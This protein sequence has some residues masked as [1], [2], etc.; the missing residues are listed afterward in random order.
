MINK[1]LLDELKQLMVQRI[2]LLIPDDASDRFAD[3]L[4]ERTAYLG[5]SS[6]DDYRTFL[7][8]GDAAEEWAELARFFTTGETFFFRDQGLHALLKDKILPELFE[9][10]KAERALRIWC[11]ACSSGEEAY[12]IAILLDELVA[13]QS[14]WNISI[15]G[16]D[17]N[18][19]FIEKAR[20]GIY[21]EWSFRG[22]SDERRQRYFHQRK[23]TWV[24]NEVIRN[25]V[26]FR[27]GNLA[28]DE[29]PDRVAG[30]YEMD[31]IL[32]RNT[33]IYMAPHVVSRIADKFAETLSEGGMLITGH[34]ELYAHHLGKLRARV[35]PE[36]IIYQKV[37]ASSFLPAMALPAEI[38]RPVPERSL[39][40]RKTNVAVPPR[41]AAEA[42]EKTTVSEMQQ[43]W[44]Y[45]NQGQRE[46]A[47]RSCGEMVAK[48]PLAAEPHYLLALLAQERGDFTEAGNLLKKVIYLDPSFIAAYLDLGDLYARDGD[49]VR[50]GK[51]RAA[52]RSLLK[53]LPGDSQVR[54]YGT[55]TVHAV[56][57]YVEH[58]LSI[59]S[60]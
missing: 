44:L 10:R 2:G 48:D 39:P 15:L 3:T 60:Q 34:G 18:R 4:R 41:A 58:Q 11:A 53:V 30:L 33:F 22:M 6:L 9:R 47:A 31:L 20:Q 55:A 35:F 36:S 59:P 25:R 1:V 49:D 42:G 24:L 17:I 27:P 57:Q 40:M 29:F 45:A 51:M 38:T 54:L 13:D 16:T 28:A 8:G 43:A 37:A 14:Q 56:L 19:D 5:Y 32:C 26:T 46:R 21:T 50:A 12:S 7:V 52:A 23:N